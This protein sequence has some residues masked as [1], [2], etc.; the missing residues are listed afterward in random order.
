MWQV[1]EFYFYG[2]ELYIIII[3]IIMFAVTVDLYVR[4]AT[5]SRCCVCHGSIQ[6]FHQFEWLTNVYL[7]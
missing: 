6:F 2:N 4:A 5:L 1:S 7:L 3:I